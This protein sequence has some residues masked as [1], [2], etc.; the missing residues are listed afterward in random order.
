MPQ[1]KGTL[2]PGKA[3]K[4][5]VILLLGTSP[6]PRCYVRPEVHRAGGRRA[7]R[8]AILDCYSTRCRQCRL[9]VP[10]LPGSG[11]RRR[12]ECYYG[13]NLQGVRRERMKCVECVKCGGAHE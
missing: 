8:S 1:I 4:R 5:T 3:V 10:G 2:T 7:L 12:A 11:V 6:L 13:C 9:P